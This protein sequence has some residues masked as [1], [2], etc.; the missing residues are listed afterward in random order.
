MV[1]E[2]DDSDSA[3]G[4]SGEGRLVLKFN[5][6]LGEKIIRIGMKGIPH[7][8]LSILGRRLSSLSVSDEAVISVVME[9]D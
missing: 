2:V 4:F 9:R 8:S 5:I 6:D 1:V 3:G 7:F